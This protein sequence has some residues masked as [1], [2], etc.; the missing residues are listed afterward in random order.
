VR[1]ERLLPEIAHAVETT[2]NWHG[3][4]WKL[5]LAEA[6][7]EIALARGDLDRA[8]ADAS[9]AIAQSQARG[10]PKYQILGLGTRAQAMLAAGRAREAIADLHSAVA[11]A[12]SLGD[13][14]LFLRSA[15]VLLAVEGNSALAAEARAAMERIG[16]ALPD[17]GMRARFGQAE[18]VRG[19][20]RVAG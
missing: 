3:W 10:R 18:P 9:A 1:A 16:Q 15:A 19:V 20:L 6:R 17:D 5:R 4:L 8:A 7:A 14:A 2:S 11:L 12:R 13:P